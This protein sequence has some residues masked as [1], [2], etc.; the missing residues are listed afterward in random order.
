MPRPASTP[1]LHSLAELAA[2]WRARQGL[3]APETPRQGDA[4]TETE[5]RP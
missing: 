4:A 5:E 1:V 2:A 3:Q